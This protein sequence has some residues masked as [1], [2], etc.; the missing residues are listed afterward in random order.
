MRGTWK[1]QRRH[2]D[3]RIRKIPFTTARDWN[4]I[5][6]ILPGDLYVT[7]GSYQ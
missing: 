1:K 5:E 2:A 6:K 3:G 7:I 4:R